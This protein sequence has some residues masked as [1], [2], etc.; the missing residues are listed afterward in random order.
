MQFLKVSV[1]S[2][3]KE[4]ELM[5][6]EKLEFKETRILA[7]ELSRRDRDYLPSDE[8]EILT[9]DELEQVAKGE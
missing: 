9:T 1:F 8:D 7:E 4:A 5:E 2:M 3:K 6:D